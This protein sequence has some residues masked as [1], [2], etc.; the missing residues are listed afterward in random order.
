MSPKTYTCKKV[1]IWTVL[2]FTAGVETVHSPLVR[3]AAQPTEAAIVL[4]ELMGEAL[5]GGGHHLAQRHYT[6]LYREE[7]GQAVE[8]EHPQQHGRGRSGSWD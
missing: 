3:A 4:P 5:A 6:A 7:L 8:E 2:P 1:P